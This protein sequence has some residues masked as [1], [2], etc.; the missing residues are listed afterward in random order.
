MKRI[1][2]K[3][4]LFT[5][6]V[7]S[8]EAKAQTARITGTVTDHLDQ[9]GI[10]GISVSIPEA[11][12]GVATDENG[13]YTF[14]HLRA[15]EYT[16]VYS[17]TG[18]QKT[19]KKI[20]LSDNESKK[21]DISLKSDIMNLSEINISASTTRQ[22]ENKMDLLAMQLQPVK[23]AQDLLRAVPGL[24]I[25]QHAGGGKAE[26][27]FVRGTDNDHGTDFAIFFDDIPV[28]LP[29]HAHGQGYADMHFMIPEVTGKA[30]FFKGPYDARLG[31]FS[32]SGAALF[33]SL[34]RLETNVAKVEYGM[35]NS[36][37]A[38]LMVNALGKK[39]LVKKW[40][41]NAYIAADYMYNDGYFINKLHY[42]RFNIF[43]KYNAH[44]S[45]NTDLTFT[46]STFSSDWDASGQL[47]LRA[48]E[49]GKLDRLGSVDPSEGGS[50][51]RTNIN[52]KT[53]TTFSDNSTFKN[54]LYYTKNIFT[55]YSNFTFFMNDSING[56]EIR[57][58]EN[59]DLF[60]YK[61]TYNR[62]DNIGNTSLSS[63]AGITTRTD[64]I[65][66]GRDHVKERQLL[67]VD[68]V[69]YAQITNYSFYINE[70]WQFH[71][72]W[73]LNLGLRND[74]FDYNYDDKLNAANSGSKWVYRFNPKLNLY[75]DVTNNVTLFAKAGSGFHSNFV[76]AVVAKD[77][78]ANPIPRSYGADLGSNF[79]LGHHMV[80]SLTAWWMHVG[81][82]YRFSGD[83]GSFEDI[84]NA[85]KVGVDASVRY[86]VT[87]FLWADVNV[88]YAHGILINAPKGE[89]LLPLHPTWNSTGGLTAK[90]KKGINASLRYRYMGDRPAT[91]DG[92][93]KSQ[94]YF[95][96]DAV[97]KYTRSRFELGISAENLF[98]VKW[99]EAQFYD[100]SRLK[101]EPAPVFDFHNTPGTPFYLKGS[102]SVFF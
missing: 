88:N 35:Y 87:P 36:Q 77:A 6:L 20:I 4:T 7:C 5:M 79:K 62:T 13:R 57:Q 33:N 94:S 28:N 45:R 86:Q 76:Q 64:L 97:I 39:H 31:D 18:Y 102:V 51:S 72:K 52:L 73:N 92:T 10:P 24:F 27:I 12:K 90:L 78:T 58:W 23:S 55:L 46:A 17:F 60:G 37:R 84:G 101:D 22:G 9:R 48:V 89:N 19:I 41:D 63:E 34:P 66:R 96:T 2:S 15:G 8:I 71:P 81:S 42:K 14:T 75:Y 69:G 98:D 74:V 32:I 61:G 70:N 3:V 83:D 53:I 68:D 40:E 95:I 59:R 1:L 43:G 80:V 26:Q 99:A 29:T 65:N 50:T 21:L 11:T 93:V 30:S 44:I 25:A 82:E 38:L 54:Q 85:R 91:E 67:S 56:D 100:E 49:A 16:I 47:P